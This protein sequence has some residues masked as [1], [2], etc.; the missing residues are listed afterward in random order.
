MGM[1]G[2]I[3]GSLVTLGI[4][5]LVAALKDGDFDCFGGSEKDYDTGPDSSVLDFGG[6]ADDGDGNADKTGGRPEPTEAHG[7]TVTDATGETGKESAGAT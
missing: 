6:F 7:S 2:F 3:A 4:V 1:K 5:G